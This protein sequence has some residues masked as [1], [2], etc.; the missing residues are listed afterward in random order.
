MFTA[1]AYNRK[2]CN[3]ISCFLFS[4]LSSVFE[5][6]SK[7][8][9]HSILHE[10]V[11]LLKVINAFH[12][13]NIVL[14]MVTSVCTIWKRWRKMENDRRFKR[15]KGVYFK[16]VIQCS[17]NFTVNLYVWKVMFISLVF[18]PF[19][20]FFVVK[21]ILLRKSSNFVPL[22]LTLMPYMVLAFNKSN[23]FCC[24]QAGKIKKQKMARI[25]FRWRWPLIFAHVSYAVL[26]F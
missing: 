21:V 22:C 18:Q 25:E 20:I 2:L 11:T 15:W 6:T 1:F 4:F 16:P 19:H 9:S 12:N 14:F 3:S 13:V 10:A 24:V 26:V 23:K 17:Q 7:S 5:W 8:L